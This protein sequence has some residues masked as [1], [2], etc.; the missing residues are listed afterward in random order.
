MV[1]IWLDHEM[2][3][4]KP[5][6][7]QTLNEVEPR[8]PQCQSNSKTQSNS[9]KIG[10]LQCNVQALTVAV[11]LIELCWF[12]AWYSRLTSFDSR[13]SRTPKRSRESWVLMA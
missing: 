8:L 3:Q 11:R 6:V 4:T 12:C 10:V 7:M 1:L 5:K 2:V 13:A 9:K